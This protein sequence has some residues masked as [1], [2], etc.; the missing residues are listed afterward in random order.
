MR[1]L[2]PFS[3]PNWSR[4]NVTTSAR[5]DPAR[6][7]LARELK[8][9]SQADLARAAD[10]T[11]AAVSQFESGHTRPADETIPILAKALSVPVAFFGVELAETHEGFFRSLRKSSVSQ[12]RHARALAHLAHDAAQS[13]P[14]SMLP[15]VTVPHC[16]VDLDASRERIEDVAARVRR[17]WGVPAGP[18]ENVVELLE[19][20][21]VVV[22]RL[23]LDSADVDAFSLPFPRHPVVVLGADKNDRAR[24]R[25]DAAHELGHLVM[26]GEQVWGLKEIEDQAH[27]FAAA[28]LMPEDDIYDE[29]P[30]RADWPLLFQLK[31]KWQVSLAALLFRAKT[32][33]R[34]TSSNYLTAIKASSAR[35]WRRSEP[36]PLGA[37][38]TPT[39]LHAYLR[40]SDARKATAHLPQQVVAALVE[41]LDD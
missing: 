14:E 29:L 27:Q 7:R 26:H 9:W 8:E 24:S 15:E 35:G 34:M 38:E 39:Q 3:I 40:T 37:P 22:I 36:V 2:R 16:S 33:G 1:A 21:G 32:L 20:H 12:R 28:F 25:F 41:A 17:E 30:P 11:P 5:L 18:V 6:L 23:P 4:Q 13:A 19:R 31:S 10:V